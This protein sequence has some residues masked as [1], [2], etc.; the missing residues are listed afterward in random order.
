MITYK[1][2][3]AFLCIFAKMAERI[4]VDMRG[5]ERYQLRRAAGK[6][7]LLDMEQAGGDYK[8]PVA[9]NETGAMILN[10]YW[11]ADDPE[12][13]AK[14]LSETYEIELEEAL[15]DVKEF[16]RQLESQGVVL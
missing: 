16:L 7:W 12:E 2:S 5:K 11:R 8:A 9:M 14:V 4:I 1:F 10:S 13:A 6:Y 15:T 3:V